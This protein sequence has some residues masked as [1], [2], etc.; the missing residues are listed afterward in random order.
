MGRPPSGPGRDEPDDDPSETP[1]PTTRRTERPPIPSPN[2]GKAPGRRAQAEEPLPNNTVVTE[3]P[4]SDEDDQPARPNRPITKPRPPLRPD[5][6][7]RRSET[8]L[9]EAID[10]EPEEERAQADD[11]D[12]THAGP[13]ISIEVV[14]GPDLGKKKRVRGGRMII[15]RGDGCDLKLTDTSASRRHIELIVGFSGAAVRDLGSGNGS[16]LNGEPLEDETPLKHNDEIIIGTTILKVVDEIKRIEELRKP[17]EPDPPPE[18]PPAVEPAPGAGA[19]TEAE[20]AEGVEHTAEI[21]VRTDVVKGAKR[22]GPRRNVLPLVAVAFAAVAV[23]SLLYMVLKSKPQP[24]TPAVLHNEASVSELMSKVK[25]AMAAKK[26]DDALAAL[27]QIKHAEPEDSSEVAEYRKHATAEKQ[28]ADTLTEARAAVAANDF[29]KARAAYQTALTLSD[30]FDANDQATADLKDIDAK[31]AAFLFSSGQALVASGD[32][33]GASNLLQKLGQRSPDKAAELTKLIGA[34]KNEIELADAKGKRDAAFVREKQ[35]QEKVAK[36]EAAVRA[37]LESGY[38]K[39]DSGDYDRAATEF[40]HISEESKNPDA[41][42]RAKQLSK[43]VKAF[44]VNFRSAKELEADQ[45]YEAEWKPLDLAINTLRD[46]EPDSPLMGKLKD[47]LARSLVIKGRSA[48]ARADYATAAKAFRAA[49]DEK[50]DSSEA[51]EG[52]RSL[53]SKAHDVFLQAYEEQSR[54][55]EQARKLFQTVMNMLSPGDPDYDKAKK[56]YDELSGGN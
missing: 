8:R 19:G 16:K 2:R 32:V 33:D 52:L 40:E 10:V 21:S 43:E 3:L 7:G 42:A 35:H 26:W 55:P 45:N 23:L 22:N 18:P 48:V 13:P 25:T 20:G 38:R 12:A 28:G 54:D 27:D 47:R 17:K 11:A 50:P 9:A 6:D 36:A 41:Q 37:E 44:G 29:D 31:E 34:K 56:R 49:L 39:F 24:E 46:I 15:G 14:H 30:A 1:A 4:E 53:R 51:K 5:G